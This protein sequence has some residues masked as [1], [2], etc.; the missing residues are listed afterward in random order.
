MPGD[1]RLRPIGDQDLPFLQRVYASTR[2]QELALV[3]WSEA[4]KQ[5]FLRMQFDAQHRHYQAH[6]PQARFD[7]IERDG[8]P[9]GRLYVDRR[10]GDIRV[11]DI[12]LL[13]A[14]RNQG[15]GGALMG[16]LLDEAEHDGRTV[17]IHVER[18]NPALA[19]YGRLG[20]RVI[21]DEGVYYLLERPPAAQRGAVTGSTAG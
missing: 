5:D 15:I 13:P 21:A 3:D 20:F 4:D 6:F 14:Y 1:I 7:L 2:E 16:D 9:L 8:E 17:S 11:I 10:P 12:A 18:N 19:F